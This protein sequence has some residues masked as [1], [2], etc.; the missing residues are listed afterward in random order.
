MKYIMQNY[1]DKIKYECKIKKRA[2]ERNERHL[3][4]HLKKE[5]I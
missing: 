5:N 4:V 1:E 3:I 2:R